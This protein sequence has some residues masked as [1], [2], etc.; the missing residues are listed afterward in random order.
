MKG[1][2][3]PTL[4]HVEK[5]VARL[6]YIIGRGEVATM[7]DA[8]GATYTIGPWTP[9]VGPRVYQFAIYGYKRGAIYSREGLEAQ[10][11][12]SVIVGIVG[13][14]RA[15]EAAIKADRKAGRGTARVVPGA[16]LGGR[17]YAAPVV[18]YDEP[19]RAAA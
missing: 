5:A 7:Q 18:V 15:R 10:T 11:A 17:R 3:Q 13:A 16:H 1:R 14:G 9:A 4:T 6:M 8:H 2:K 19:E 12:A